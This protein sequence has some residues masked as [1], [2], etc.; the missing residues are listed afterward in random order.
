MLA[1]FLQ[2]EN[3]Q[4]GLGDYLLSY[5]YGNADAKDL[6]NVLSRNIV[7]QTLDVKVSIQYNRMLQNYYIRIYLPVFYFR[8]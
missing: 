2:D 4:N 3:L 7:N 8:V 1:D 5:K 6:W